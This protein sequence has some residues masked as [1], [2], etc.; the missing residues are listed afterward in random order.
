M[1]IEI[2]YYVPN[3]K[4]F[5]GPVN[6]SMGSSNNCMALKQIIPSPRVM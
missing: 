3:N 4:W 6:I 1:D 5:M 2:L